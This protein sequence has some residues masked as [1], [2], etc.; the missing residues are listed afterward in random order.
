MNALRSPQQKRERPKK[1]Q[2]HSPAFAK[3]QWDKEGLFDR[4]R[5]W[6]TGKRVS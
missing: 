1:E 5:N 4:L 3:V 2:K 6:T